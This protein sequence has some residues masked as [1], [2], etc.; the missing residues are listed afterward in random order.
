[1]SYE[2]L[3][4]IIVP[5]CKK[6]NVPLDTQ[7]RDDEVRSVDFGTRDGTCFQFWIDPPDQGGN[8]GVH[9]LDYKKRLID[10]VATV[11]TL[12]EVLNEVGGIVDE[13]VE[14]HNSQIPE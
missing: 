9:L 13:W 5:W 12:E 6:R 4:P 7:Y 8:I 14:S 10:R 11:E 3:D 1:M 2:L